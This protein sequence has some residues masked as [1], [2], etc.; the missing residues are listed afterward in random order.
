MAN[1]KEFELLIK[2]AGMIDPSLESS[3]EKAKLEMQS[4]A[5]VAK[6]ASRGGVTAGE[7]FSDAGA[8]IDGMWNGAKATIRTT[9]EVLLAAGAAATLAGSWALNAGSNFESAFAGVEKTVDG[10]E[11]ELEALEEQIRRMSKEKP[12][13]ASELAEIAESAG[14]LGI[15]IP[16]IVGF[17]GVMADLSVATNLAR[18]E[19]ASQLA[20]FANI[21]GMVQDKF[22]NLGSTVVDLGNHMATTEADIMNMGMRLAGAGTQVGMSEADIMGLAAS[23]SSVGIEAEAGGSA[24]SK[25]MIQMQLAVEKGGGALGSFAKVANMSTANFKKAFKQDAAGAITAFIS[26]LGDT[27]RLGKSAIAVLDDMEIKEVRLRDTLLRAAGA[28]GTFSGAIAMANK[29]FEENTALSKEAEKRYATFESRV[30]MVGNRINDLGITLYQDFRDPLSEVLNV[31]TQAADE[32]ELFDPAFIEKAAQGFKDNIP[33]MI[34]NLRE[35]G[36][37]IEDFARPFMALGDWMLEHPDVIVGALAG[38]GTTIATLKLGKSIYEVTTSIT[39]LIAAMAS[40]PVTAAIGIVALAGG[41]MV[42]LST[43]IK[44]AQDRARK[45]RLDKDF[46]NITLSIKEMQEAVEHILTPETVE[47]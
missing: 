7:A 16:N 15:Q 35:A 38:I 26:G 40:N 6:D 22:G 18:E 45:A 17:T 43:Q 39:G 31:A 14:Q 37:T 8:G 33:T 28:S 5:K 44:M 9:A 46:G 42:G 29:A 34:R 20:K 1:A 2:L 21:T 41:A 24:M 12:L 27:E 19:G 36:D 25:V 30:D 3:I 11:K 47:I 32:V 13:T 4:M 23:L 10:T